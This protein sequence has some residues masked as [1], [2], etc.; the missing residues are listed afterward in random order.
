[1]AKMPMTRA[2][3]VKKVVPPPK[4][5]YQTTAKKPEPDNFPAKPRGSSRL[6]RLKN[7]KL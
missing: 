1:M 7:K 2:G 6:G 4:S 3:A 5:V